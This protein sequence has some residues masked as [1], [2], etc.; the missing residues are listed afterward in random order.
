M[1]QLPQIINKNS[2]SSKKLEKVI[3]AKSLLNKNTKNPFRLPTDKEIFLS[4]DE[5]ISK[6][7]YSR[8]IPKKIWEKFTASTRSPLKKVNMESISQDLDQRINKTINL[9]PK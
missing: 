9:N 8:N 5:L 1:S 7:S 3:R 6:K 4:R 2:I